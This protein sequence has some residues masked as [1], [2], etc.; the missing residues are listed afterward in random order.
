MIFLVVWLVCAWVV[1]GSIAWFH[2]WRDP[3]NSCAASSL[4][5]SPWRPVLSVGFIG[6]QLGLSGSSARR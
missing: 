3:G 6:I 5:L 4:K 2:V 1:D